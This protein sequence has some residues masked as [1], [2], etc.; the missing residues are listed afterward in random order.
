MCRVSWNAAASTSWSPQRLSRP[1]VRL[2][3]ILQSKQYNKNT[4]LKWQA[5][6]IEFCVI[7]TCWI[8]KTK[9]EDRHYNKKAWRDGTCSDL[10]GISSECLMSRKELKPGYSLTQILSFFHHVTCV[11]FIS[12]LVFTRNQT[13]NI[14]CWQSVMNY[15]SVNFTSCFVIWFNWPLQITVINIGLQILPDV[16]LK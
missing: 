9:Y 5:P 16:K 7:Y 8:I 13:S 12:C 1:A 6:F 15:I 14:F 2:L 3:Y 4:K 11:V 10:D